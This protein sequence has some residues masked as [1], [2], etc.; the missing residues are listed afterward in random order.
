MKPSLAAVLLAP[1]EFSLG[2]P[3]PRLKDLLV[4]DQS[5]SQGVSPVLLLPL[6]TQEDRPAGMRLHLAVRPRDIQEA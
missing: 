6:R 2:L 1:P 4:R 3:A 5:T